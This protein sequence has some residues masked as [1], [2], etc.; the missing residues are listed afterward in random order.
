MY[1]LSIVVSNRGGM[2]L[3]FEVVRVVFLN[4]VSEF[5]VRDIVTPAHGLSESY[6]I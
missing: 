5:R 4:M 6:S 1:G 2:A 3:E